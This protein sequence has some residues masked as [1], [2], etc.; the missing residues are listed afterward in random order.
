MLARRFMDPRM[1]FAGQASVDLQNTLIRKILELVQR[2]ETLPDHLARALPGEGV[3][4]S[5]LV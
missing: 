5:R 4:G 3:A 1:N 2:R